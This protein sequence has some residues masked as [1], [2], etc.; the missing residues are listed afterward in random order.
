MADVNI[1]LE[2][3]TAGL[4]HDFPSGD[5]WHDHGML[6]RYY[7]FILPPKNA[8]HDP[9]DTQHLGIQCE[10]GDQ[11][12]FR[13]LPKNGAQDNVI[14]FR[15]EDFISE[16]AGTN[17][18][19]KRWLSPPIFQ[20]YETTG[21]IYNNES[22]SPIQH[23]PPYPNQN[24]SYWDAPLKTDSVKLDPVMLLSAR[25]STVGESISGDHIQ[26]YMAVMIRYQ[27]RNLRYYYDPFIRIYERGQL[28]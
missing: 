22:P 13:T 25:R 1:F 15:F 27:G 12:T 16:G 17:P 11:L 21:N 10:V 9:A 4:L 14:T 7:E 18:N 24:W 26:F 2:V 20:T 23:H 19:E 6:S 8:Y 5:A 28:P 3:D